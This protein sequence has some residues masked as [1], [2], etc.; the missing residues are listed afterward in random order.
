MRTSVRLTLVAC[1]SLL[2]LVF[3][4]AAWSAYEPSLLVA[5]ARQTL[6]VPTAVVIGVAQ[7][8]TDDPT[9]KIDIT[10]PEGYNERLVASPGTVIGEVFATVI[11]RGAGNA[12]VDVSGQV[13]ADNPASHVSNACAPGLHTA[14]W[15]LEVTLAGTPVRVPIYVDD[16]TNVPGTSARIQLCLAGPVGT[17]SGSQLLTA[18]FEVR[19]VFTNPT[20][21]RAHIWSALF[22]PYNPGTPQPNPGGT[23]EARAIVPLPVTVT[24][25]AKRKGRIVTLSGRVNLPGNAIPSTIEIWSGPSSRRLRRVTRVR[26]RANGTFTNRRRVGKRTRVLFYQARLDTP[27]ANAEA[28]GFCQTPPP[29]APRGCVSAVFAALD[30]R[31]PVRRVRFPRR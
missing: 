16:I 5:S 20:A 26:V 6:S 12:E 8:N 22:T 21:R 19:D 28:F 9:A 27:F 18:V 15:I 14:V 13:R 4:N 31:G 3:A 29:R 17:P 23:V 7:S 24:M 1:A 2:A 11:L 25:T 30:V 10:V